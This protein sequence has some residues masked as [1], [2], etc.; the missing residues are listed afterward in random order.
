M[1]FFLMIRRPPRSTLFPY[2]TLFRS[3]RERYQ[4]RRGRQA[5]T[6]SRR[7]APGGVRAGATQRL[8]AQGYGTWPRCRPEDDRSHRGAAAP[9]HGELVVARVHRAAVETLG[10]QLGQLAG[11]LAQGTADRDAEDALAAGEQVDDLLG[12]G[13]LVDRRTVGEQGHVGEVLDPARAQV[14]DGLA[15]VLQRDTGVEQP[16]DDLQHEDVAERVQPLRPDRKS[17]RLNSSH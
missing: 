9:A 8:S 1:F 4:R 3:L 17:T 16:L 12:G 13:A 6:R 11:E 5:T 2:T 7:A 14:V 10:G 15:D